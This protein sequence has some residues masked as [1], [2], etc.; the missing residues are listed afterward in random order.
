MAYLKDLFSTT[1]TP[2]SEPIPGSAQAPNS[3]GGHAW[4]VD[5]WT[6]LDRFLILG[7][8]GGSYY[9]TERKLSLENAKAVARCLLEDGPRTVARI[10]EISE[11]GRAPKQDPA[12][13]SLAL[14]T[15]ERTSA[16]G[17]QAALAALPRV[18]R[19][20]THLFQFAGQ[21]ESLRGWG[22][23]LRRAVAGWYGMPAEQLAYQAVKYQAREGWSHRDLL[24]LAHPK[25]DAESA[26]QLVYRWIVKGRESAPEAP[27]R[28]EARLIWAFERAKRAETRAEIVELIREHRLPREAVPTQWLTDAAVWDALLDDMPMTAMIR[29]LATMT[30][31]GL[32]SPN[33]EGTRRVIE[34]LKDGQ[35]LQRA[36][37]HPIAVLA[38][39]KTY[40]QGHGER[41]RNTWKPVPRV[42]DALDRA[43]Y[44]AFGSVTPTGRRWLLALDVSGSMDCGSV[45]GV[46]GL[47]PR[48]ASA[49]M[50]L[51]TA[52]T[53]A[54]HTVVGFTAAGGGY[55]GRW[56]GGNPDLTRLDVTP[57]QRLDAVVRQVSRLPMGGTDCALPMLW[58]LKRKVPV[59]VF[60]VYTDSETWAGKIHPAQALRQYRERMGIPAKLI[61]V[62]MVSN[63]FSIADPNDGGMLDVVGFDTAAPNLMS[64][65]AVGSG[66]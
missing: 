37:V 14:A 65:F 4:P 57:G 50:A 62:G 9:A 8:E 34:R 45:A 40:A 11:S 38:A 53:E 63:G 36:R 15:T 48:V 30:R 58:A 41:G 19:T 55:G 64:D 23:G 60:A 25:V 61:V 7:S 66:D 32:I 16:E 6:R 18:C 17:R 12:I 22:R 46:P 31:V 44:L 52:S 10:V 33:S 5:H 24:R 20:G 27:E 28:P 49:A 54:E 47:T 56:G 29:N 59:D 51:I 39:L 43:F 1:R 35:R 2:Q 21:V 26:H 42:V 3:A 13:L